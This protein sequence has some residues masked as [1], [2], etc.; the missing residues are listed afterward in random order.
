[1]FTQ[2]T[3]LA[4][5]ALLEQADAGQELVSNTKIESRAHNLNWLL[6]GESRDR[7]QQLTAGY[8]TELV[9]YLIEGLTRAKPEFV[10]TPF[11][12]TLDGIIAGYSGNSSSKKKAR[13]ALSKMLS[14]AKDWLMAKVVAEMPKMNYEVRSTH[15]TFRVEA[16]SPEEAQL[17]AAAQYF[18]RSI[19]HVDQRRLPEFS[20]GVLVT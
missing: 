14:E 2:Q 8:H 9:G 12:L 7:L 6:I 17:E 16:R 20:L 13:V 15:G 11:D 10:D 19:E 5:N 18:C 4:L 1:M 3:I